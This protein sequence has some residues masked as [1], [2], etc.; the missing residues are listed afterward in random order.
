MRSVCG[1]GGQGGRSGLLSPSLP[2]R[3]QRHGGT[4]VASPAVVVAV[5]EGEQH[6][7]PLSSR[8]AVYPWRTALALSS[9]KAAADAE[10]RA[11]GHDVVLLLTL[12]QLLRKRDRCFY[13]P[14]CCPARLAPLGK[15][16]ALLRAALVPCVTQHVRRLPRM[17]KPQ[18]RR[19]SKRTARQAPRCAHSSKRLCLP[20]RR[21]ASLHAAQPDS[22]RLRSATLPP[23]GIAS[24]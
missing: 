8:V 19:E 14:V 15:C 1:A 11:E 21:A 20:P 2:A 22:A 18:R 12:G 13:L 17:T 24:E 4:S 16:A 6:A 9:L 7:P 23:A 5:E 3:A 10:E